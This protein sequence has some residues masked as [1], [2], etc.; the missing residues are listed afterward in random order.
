MQSSKYSRYFNRNTGNIIQ[1]SNDGYMT[2]VG[3]FLWVPAHIGI[4]GNEMAN[5]APKKPQK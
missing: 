4:K 2:I 5:K 3:I 1:N